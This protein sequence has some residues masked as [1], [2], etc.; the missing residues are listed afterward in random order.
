MHMAL[1]CVQCLW[2]FGSTTCRCVCALQIKGKLNAITLDQCTK[3]GLVFESVV[4]ACEVVNSRSVQVPTALR[5]MA[6]SRWCPFMNVAAASRGGHGQ[7]KSY[8][9]DARVCRSILKVHDVHC[10]RCSAPVWCRQSPSTR[11]TAA[12]SAHF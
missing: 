2:H 1:Y 11:S 7:R 9:G 12:R 5:V 8:L 6:S 10:C 3:C 4:A